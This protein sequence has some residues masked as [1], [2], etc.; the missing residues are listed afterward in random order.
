MKDLIIMGAGDLSKDVCWLVERINDNRKEWNLLGFTEISEEKEFMGYPIL[1]DDNV[2]SDYPNAWVICAV[3]NQKLRNKIYDNLPE[4]TKVATLIDPIAM[5]HKSAVIEE[6][7]MVFAN[8]L[9]GVGAH[10]SKGVVVLYNSYVNHD[11]E[12]GKCVTIYP[13]ATI[14]GKSVIGDYAEIGTGVSII[15]HKKICE[16]ATI[17]AGA[18]VFTNIKDTGTTI[19]NPAVTMGA[20]KK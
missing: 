16:G 7:S 9:V 3:A 17:G 4:G 6:G 5:I 10:L 20:K 14:S 1:G 2:V 8:S 12:V 13:S 11:C 18:V 15:Q 19:G